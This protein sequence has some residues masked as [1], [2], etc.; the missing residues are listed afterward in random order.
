MD[1][2]LRYER[3]NPPGYG[4]VP[5]WKKRKPNPRGFTCPR[6]DKR[7][8]YR[9]LYW[10]KYGPMKIMKTTAQNSEMAKLHFIANCD[11]RGTLHLI[12]GYEVTY[13]RD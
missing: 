1:N 7:G 13:E 12:Q 3:T 8:L 9:I 4:D 11:N 6:N 5:V 2:N 10:Y